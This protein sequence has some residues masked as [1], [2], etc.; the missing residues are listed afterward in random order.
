MNIL[1]TTSNIIFILGVMGAVFGVYTYFRDPQIA[2]DKQQDLDKQEVEGKAALLEERTK[3]DRDQSEKRFVDM[4]I[5]LDTAFTLAQNHTH[6]VDVK[7]DK[8]IDSVNSLGNFVTKLETIIDE[9][10]PKK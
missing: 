6:T 4:G 1:L 5:R 10:I 3:W 7:V 8:L 9:R 2:L